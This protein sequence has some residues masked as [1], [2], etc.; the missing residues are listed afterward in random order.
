MHGRIRYRHN[1]FKNA[2]SSG[3]D[4]IINE[5]IKHASTLFKQVLLKLFNA[6]F[7]TGIFP[8]VWAIGEIVPIH[9]KGDVNDPSNYRGI[10]LMSCLGKL[11]TSII[12]NRLTNW[13]EENHVYCENQF[14]FRKEKGTTDCKFILHGIIE[15]TI[16]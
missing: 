14:G 2:K 5:F 15:I 12:N 9:K 10:T 16:K 8:K 1:T 13:A 7:N 4:G 3:F 6:I 11:F